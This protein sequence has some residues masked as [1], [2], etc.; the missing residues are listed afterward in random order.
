MQINAQTLTSPCQTGL[1]GHMADDGGVYVQ[2]SLP[3]FR[4]LEDMAGTPSSAM[5]GFSLP[6]ACAF[7]TEGGGRVACVPAA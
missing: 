7:T 1:C 3:R 2:A 4:L 5:S 6:T